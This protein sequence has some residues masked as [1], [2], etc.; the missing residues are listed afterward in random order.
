LYENGRLLVGAASASGRARRRR[1]AWGTAGGWT[2]RS[3]RASGRTCATG[4]AAAASR[5][6]AREAS[7]V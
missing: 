5:A 6:R 4:G 3:T 7:A 1:G 2:C